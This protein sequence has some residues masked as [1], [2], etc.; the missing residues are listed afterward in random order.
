[1]ELFATQVWVLQRLTGVLAIQEPLPSCLFARE[2]GGAGLGSV[3][4][5]GSHRS[6]LEPRL[7]TS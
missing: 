5:W 1:M 4:D 3:S 6:T 2:F 7:G